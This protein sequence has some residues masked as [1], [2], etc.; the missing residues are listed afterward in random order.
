MI[1]VL[2]RTGLIVFLFCLAYSV[3]LCEEGGGKLIKAG[4]YT[5]VP[6]PAAMQDESSSLMRVKRDASKHFESSTYECGSRRSCYVSLKTCDIDPRTC[7]YVLSWDYD[8]ENVNF[9]L[10]ALT[11]AWISVVLS[12]DQYY[13]IYKTNSQ[14]R[15]LN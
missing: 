8:S 1:S 3:V 4:D 12:D 2:G 5:A 13:V 7:N 15:A 14:P 6:E 10:S 9:E 11:H